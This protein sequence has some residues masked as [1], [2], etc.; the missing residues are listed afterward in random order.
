MSQFIGN[1]SILARKDRRLVPSYQ[2]LRRQFDRIQDRD[3]PSQYP[4]G[5]AN[6]YWPGGGG[7]QGAQSTEVPILAGVSRD[8]S[9]RYAWGAASRLAFIGVTRDAQGTLL[10]GVT[11][12]LFRTADKTLIAEI[13]SGVDGSFFLQSPFTDGH[14]IVFNKT[15]AQDVFGTTKQT[16]IGA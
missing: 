10:G 13:V 14:F 9:E 5:Y 7:L 1:E 3:L 8:V 11:C 15:G 12:S 2:N 16:L 6:A 4:G